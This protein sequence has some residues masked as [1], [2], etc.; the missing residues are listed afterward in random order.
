MVVLLK[1]LP[2]KL[3]KKKQQMNK[4]R[5]Y[6]SNTPKEYTEKEADLIANNIAAVAVAFFMFLVMCLGILFV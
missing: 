3:P 1:K 5:H 2:K 6:E 4:V